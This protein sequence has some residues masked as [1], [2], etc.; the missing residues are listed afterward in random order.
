MAKFVM[1]DGSIVSS[2]KFMREKE[3]KPHISPILI[4]QLDMIDTLKTISKNLSNET[5]DNKC[6][7]SLITG[8]NLS[9]PYDGNCGK[10][11]CLWYMKK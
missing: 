1:D 8:E 2:D 4:A 6:I 3:E 11:I 7:M 5:L 9:C 10:C